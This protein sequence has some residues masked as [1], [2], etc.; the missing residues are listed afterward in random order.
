LLARRVLPGAL[1]SLWR[2]VRDIGVLGRRRR[3]FW[4]L[5]AGALPGGAPALA[6]AVTLAV[7]GEHMIRY[8]EETVLPRLDR[9]IALLVGERAPAERPRLGLRGFEPLPA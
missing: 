7:M 8:T 5:L 3:H 2:A 4:R 9:A 6:R 1:G